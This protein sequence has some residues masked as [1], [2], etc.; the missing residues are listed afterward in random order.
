VRPVGRAAFTP[1][2][3]HAAGP[4]PDLTAARVGHVAPEHV[5]WSANL[6]A[7]I[8][9]AIGAAA[10]E[11]YGARAI[12]I[13]L[14]M[15]ADPAK[16]ARQHALVAQA[17]PGLA[18]ELAR[19]A[20]PV[21]NLGDSARL[22]L[23][24]LAINALRQLSPRQ[25]QDFVKLLHAV[26]RADNVITLAEY[27]LVRLVEA[28]LFPQ[29]ARQASIFALHPLRDALALV[30]S[31]LANEGA[32]DPAQARAAFAA[33]CAGLGADLQLAL[34]PAGSID[35]G[36]LDRALTTLDQASAALKRQVI[37]ACA[38]C[39]AD[40]GNVT[41]REAELLRL[42]ADCLGCPLPPFIVGA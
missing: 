7:A 11:T 4:Q 21:Q 20:L 2:A 29:H 15:D 24:T 40:D 9:P 30:L 16:A 22:P 14:L 26:I 37:N 12:L 27:S 1:G 38:A 36:H 35:P 28:N 18:Q 6:L 10:R 39:I 3:A 33:G 8:P 31:E 42:I 17:D 41:A 5:A 13:S 32:T 25:A 34:L 23:S 19:L